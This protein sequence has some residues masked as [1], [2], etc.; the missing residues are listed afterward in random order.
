MLKELLVEHDL[1]PTLVP[2]LTA[3]HEIFIDA[4]RVAAK[5]P[6]PLHHIFYI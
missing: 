5:L 1:P 6:L 4:G 3:K 2:N